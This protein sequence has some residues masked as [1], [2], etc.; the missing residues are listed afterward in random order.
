MARVK[1]KIRRALI[2]AML[3]LVP[4]P[5]AAASLN[6]RR[7]LPRQRPDGFARE[8]GYRPGWPARRWRLSMHDLLETGAAKRYTPSPREPRCRSCGGMSR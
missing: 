7:S 6:M 5:A 1:G 8:N 3:A 2:G 4:S